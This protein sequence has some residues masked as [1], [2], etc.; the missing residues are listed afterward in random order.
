[1]E[2]MLGHPG[3]GGCP[4]SAECDHCSMS[5]GAEDKHNMVEKPSPKM[6]ATINRLHRPEGK[7]NMA[8]KPCSAQPS[9]WNKKQEQVL[10][11]DRVCW[12][13]LGDSGPGCQLPCFLSMTYMCEV[14]AAALCLL[15][16]PAALSWTVTGP[17][18]K[19]KKGGEE[20][21]PLEH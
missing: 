9:P 5:H 12:H 8:K 6:A 21:R 19:G 18:P 17:C 16:P 14:S 20:S 13:C 11:A 15:L 7:D 3:P 1:M 4:S 2:Y 10:V